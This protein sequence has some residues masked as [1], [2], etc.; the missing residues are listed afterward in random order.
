M[1]DSKAYAAL[2]QSVFSA[3]ETYSNVHRGSGHFSMVTTSLFEK[4]REIVLEY[5]NL[6][7]DKYSVI[8][9]TPSREI[10][11]RALLNPLDYKSISSLDIGLSIGVRAMAV[12]SKA[13]PGGV[14][15][16]S[17]GGTARLVARDWVVWADKPDRFEAGTPPIINVI[18]FAKALLLIHQFGNDA[19]MKIGSDKKNLH[20]I[21]YSDDLVN[22]NGIELLNKVRQS[23]IGRNI[24][25]PCY[26][27]SRPF[28]YLDNA[29]TTPAFQEVWN[30]V[31]NTWNQ[32]AE[33]KTEIIREVRSVCA[34]YLN[35]PLADYDI[36]FTSN[37]TEAINL[38]AESLNRETKNTT[39]SVVLNTLLE[40]N[41]NDLPWRLIPGYSLIRLNINPEGFVDPVELEMLLSD[42]NL[43]FLHGKKRIKLVAVSGAS[44]VLGTYNNLEE[45]SRIVHKYEAHLL[46]DAAQLIAHR[47]IETE[48]WGI[49]YLTFSAHKAYAPFG[50][51][52]L[53][54]RKGLLNFSPEELEKIHYSGE[55]NVVGIAAMGKALSVLQNIGL[56]IIM[57]EEQILTKKAIEVLSQINGIKIHGIKNTES[58]LFHK[59]GGVISF[60]FKNFM[61]DVVA[62]ELARNGIGVRYGCHCAHILIKH[63][64]KV[65]PSLERLQKI[66]VKVFPRIVLPGVVRVSFGTGTSPEDIDVFTRVMAG[67]SKNSAGSLDSRIKDF[68]NERVQKVFG[69]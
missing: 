35:A 7:K 28:I 39:G 32:P 42:Y 33:M 17:G 51:G 16:Q 11:L 56:D 10:A 57:E 23:I 63:L 25:V 6:K 24:P 21:L 2:E 14:P 37:T 18:T 58:P 4:A 65:P 41:S 45:I 69:F 13:L 53:V 60:S 15:F 44:N 62:K 29:A 43:K 1:F 52:V 64:L 3:L 12:R 9:C 38:A 68:V 59:R 46:V 48:K 47:N 22:Y 36:I 49:D 54:I 27:G 66:I 34:G 20:D 19:F 67:F 26:A 40:H 55:E 50:S 30:V 61:P 5:L 8:F 31:C